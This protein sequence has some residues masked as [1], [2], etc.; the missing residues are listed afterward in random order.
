MV[1]WVKLPKTWETVDPETFVCVLN[2]SAFAVEERHPVKP[3][4]KNVNVGA[5]SLSLSAWCS[6]QLV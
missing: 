1:R 4:R 5:V 3:P 2:F 6:F